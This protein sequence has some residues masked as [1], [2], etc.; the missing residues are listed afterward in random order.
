M[1]LG[2]GRSQAIRG[3][4][5]PVSQEINVESALI[6]APHPMDEEHHTARAGSHAAGCQVAK[7]KWGQPETTHSLWG[8]RDMSLGEF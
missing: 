2:K 3:H 6:P 7:Q 8:C 4:Q 1:N 5:T